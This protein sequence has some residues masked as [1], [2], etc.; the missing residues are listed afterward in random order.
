MNRNNRYVDVDDIWEKGLGHSAEF[1]TNKD[2]REI[3][4]SEIENTSRIEKLYFE[5]IEAM[6]KYAREEDYYEDDS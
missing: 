4:T 2:A 1:R 6:K 5:A 3:D